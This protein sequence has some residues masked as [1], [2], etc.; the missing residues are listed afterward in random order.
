[1]C[2]SEIQRPWPK[3]TLRRLLLFVA[4]VAFGCAALVQASEFWLV[5]IATLTFFSILGF[6]L[7]AVF[8]HGS[9]R[10]FA[11]GFSICSLVYIIVAYGSETTYGSHVLD[12]IAI[13][14]LATTWILEHVWWG[15]VQ[16]K[17]WTPN[18]DIVQTPHGMPYESYH[19]MNIG[20]LLWALFIGWLGGRFSTYLTAAHYDRQSVR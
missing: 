12:N 3:F 13:R 6:I 17:H 8:A 14:R 16:T 18:I 10:V 4:V 5:V 19:F 11:I 9:F 2:S 1:M 15:L 20:Q 7:V